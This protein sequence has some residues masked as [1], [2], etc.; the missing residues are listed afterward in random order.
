MIGEQGWF[1]FTGME[2]GA[3]I[4]KTEPSPT[5]I[6]YCSY[7]PT[8]YGDVLHWEDATT[9][10]LSQNTDDAAIH[11]VPFGDMPQG[12]GVI[13]GNITNGGDIPTS[14]G[15]PIILRI[16]GTS[17]A[18]MLYADAQGN[19]E[20][21]A[22]GYGNYEL[23]AEIPGKSMVPILIT[24]SQSSPSATGISMIVL[25]EEI[26]FGTGETED[27]QNIS[28]VFPNP[29][30]ESAN[31]IVNPRNP[32]SVEIGIIDITG[33]VLQSEKRKIQSLEKIQVD[34]SRIPSGVYTLRIMTEKMDMVTRPFIKR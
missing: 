17:V 16:Q 6:Y 34:L 5:S 8:Y 11:L 22:M 30:Y 27:F 2:S 18:T 1:E 25:P 20:F 26:V 23:F 4:V 15:I 31:I 14:D 21:T 29:A 9:I 13:R 24:L 28:Q 12:T 32:V 10:H 33:R 7:L 19:F 3:Y